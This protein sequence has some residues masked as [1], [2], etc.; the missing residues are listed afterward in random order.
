MHAN[1]IR[2]MD[3]VL[4]SPHDTDLTGSSNRDAI[5]QFTGD[6][7][8]FIDGSPPASHIVDKASGY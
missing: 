7:Q 8:H 2:D 6:V 4:L 1:F 5:K 3:N